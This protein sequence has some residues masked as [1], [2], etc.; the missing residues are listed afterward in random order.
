[1][2]QLELHQYHQGKDSINEYIDGFEEL[3]E[4]AEYRASNCDEVSPKPQPLHPKHHLN[5]G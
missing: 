3:V 1:M 4:R 5:G 2:D